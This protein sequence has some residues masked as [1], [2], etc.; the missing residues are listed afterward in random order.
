MIPTGAIIYFPYNSVSTMRELKY[1]PTFITV[2]PLA[3]PRASQN[4]N[5]VHGRARTHLIH[6]H[7][8]FDP[9]RA[10]RPMGRDTVSLDAEVLRIL[11]PRLF[12]L[13]L[14]LSK[15]PPESYSAHR[16]LADPQERRRRDGENT[17]NEDEEAYCCANLVKLY[18]SHLL[19]AY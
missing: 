15:C 1:D 8:Q 7:L 12:S 11:L 3:S 18:I 16:S 10:H 19:V 6:L 4:T 17:D 14:S 13:S 5:R 2:H 9:P